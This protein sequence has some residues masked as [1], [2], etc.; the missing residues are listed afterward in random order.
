MSCKKWPL[1]CAG[2]AA[3][4]LLTA[5]GGAPPGT[6]ST[7]VA[8]D[9]ALTLYQGSDVLGGPNLHFADLLSKGK[10]VILNFW[11]AD[12][13]PCKAEMPDLQSVQAQYGDEMIL[14]GLDVGPFLGLG[15]RDGGKAR[16]KELG[17]TYPAGT[18][19]DAGVL[20]AYQLLGMP[21]TVFIKP[22]GTIYK[23]RLGLM[24]K[25]DME[26]SFKDL[27]DASKKGG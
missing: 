6:S 3:V 8:P 14:F 4:L 27:L 10:P 9:F 15:S 20:A 12:C 5:C 22:G 26:T 1:F 24:T 25:G 11:A 2:L 21:T 7:A 16:I 19:F 23:R 17:V 18:T 13:P